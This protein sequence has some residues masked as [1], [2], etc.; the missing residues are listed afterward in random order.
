MRDEGL[1]RISDKSFTHSNVKEIFFPS[2]YNTIT[3]E[4]NKKKNKKFLIRFSTLLKM[5]INVN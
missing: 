3:Q 2:K 1:S 5:E 4:S